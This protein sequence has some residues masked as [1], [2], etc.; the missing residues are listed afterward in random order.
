MAEDDPY[1]FEIEIPGGKSGGSAARSKFKDD[2]ESDDD[3]GDADGGGESDDDVSSPEKP[4]AK[5]KPVPKA[6]SNALDKA[7]NFLSKYSSKQP[8]ASRARVSLEFSD[9]DDDEP[10]RAKPSKSAK[11]SNPQSAK[12]ETKKKPTYD[13]I[14]MEL[15]DDEDDDDAIPT[16]R[17]SKMAETS[18]GDTG[19][20]SG[21]SEFEDSGEKPPRAVMPVATPIAAAPT[22]VIPKNETVSSAPVTQTIQ[23]ARAD[24][25]DDDAYVPSRREPPMSM[26]PLVKDDEA[27]EVDE[28]E[29]SIADE[30]DNGE[31]TKASVATVDKA[32]KTD[33][34]FNYSMDFSDDESTKPLA[35]IPANAGGQLPTAT[36]GDTN[37]EYLDESFA[38]SVSPAKPPVAMAAVP[39][40][41][42]L[43]QDDEY[44]DE[45]FAESVEPPSTQELPER[46][47]TPPPTTM[48][49]QE[50]DNASGAMDDDDDEP[51]RRQETRVQPEED[52]YGDDTFLGSAEPLPHV[53]LPLAAQARIEPM[54]Q[55]VHDQPIPHDDDGCDKKRDPATQREVTMTPLVAAPLPRRSNVI[56]V[57]EYELTPRGKVEMKDASTQFTGNHVQIQADL[58]PNTIEPLR[59]PTQ[60]S[61]MTAP[62][63]QPTE[64]TQ[65]KTPLQCPNPV[66]GNQAFNMASVNT[67]ISTS[68]YRQQLQ[69]IQ[70]QIRRKRM[71]S[72]R[73]MR[74]AMAYRYTSVES[75]EKVRLRGTTE[76]DEDVTVHWT[77][78]AT[79]IGHVGGVD[80]G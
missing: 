54:Q 47:E 52:E 60:E 55:A 53:V 65:D 16:Q 23:P 30:G 41:P 21:L 58:S 45:S 25:D 79:Q 44:M 20:I 34:A 17:K 24:S 80:A 64:A 32:G 40:A 14:S 31:P 6:A 7:K 10:P 70:M 76:I 63:Q 4:K 78:S 15:S 74:E 66:V 49:V 50:H 26:K 69:Q 28:V 11:T 71:E 73:V 19:A 12:P 77:E 5:A 42:T 62:S 8:V 9:D 33:Q 29:D 38:E 57:R 48:Q 56:I 18:V 36:T 43:H 2:D 22:A 37:D 75:A 61:N 13:D 39:V 1:N 68:L 46:Q 59:P 51:G 67:S 72:E 3:N 27:S 35:S